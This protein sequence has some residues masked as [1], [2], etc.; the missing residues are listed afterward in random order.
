M[1]DYRPGLPE[2]ADLSRVTEDQLDF[3]H[4]RRVAR[5]A[6]CEAHTF[7]VAKRIACY[8]PTDTMYGMAR[9]FSTLCDLEPGPAEAHAFQTLPEALAWLGRSETRLED[10]AGFDTIPAE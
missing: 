5:E 3:N 2:L 10:I 9:M 6:N 7:G 4:M 1:P 8:A